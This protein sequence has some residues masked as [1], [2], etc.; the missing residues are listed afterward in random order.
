MLR[1]GT[2]NVRGLSNKELELTTEL[3]QRNIN[4]AITPETKKKLNGTKEINDYVMIYSG[5]EQSARAAKG[6]AIWVDKKWKNKILGYEFLNERI[7][8]VR[9][10]TERGKLLVIGVYAPDLRFHF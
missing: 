5:V 9:F 3:K 2:W 10:K 4:I 1:I 8:N 6:I 7:V